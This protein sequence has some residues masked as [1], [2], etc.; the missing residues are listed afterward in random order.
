MSDRTFVDTNVLVYAIDDAEPEKR[1]IAREVLGS[2]RYGE[3]VL[4]TQVLGEFYVTVTRKLAEPVSE[5]KAEEAVQWLGL[6]PTLPID[7]TLI[8]SAIQTSRSAQLSYWDGLIVAAAARAGCE[9][10]LTEDLNDGQ[11]IG[12]VRIENPFRDC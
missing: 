5:A 9:R 12:S 7:P 3:F 1:D 4:S 8:K 6:N 10:L 2:D 11:E